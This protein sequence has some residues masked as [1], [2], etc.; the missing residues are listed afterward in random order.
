MSS[1]DQRVV[2][3]RFNNQQF[4][5]G[6]SQSTQSLEKLKKGLDLEGSAKSLTNL[7]NAG[8]NFSLANISSGI[9]TLVS[10]FSS[11]GI[12]GMTVLQNIT[13]QALYAGQNLAAALTTTPIFD[14]FSEYEIKMNSIQTLLT[15]TADKGSTLA[16]V[17]KILAE[18]NDYADQ[19]IYNKCKRY[20]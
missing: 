19:T 14:G 20:G 18:L 1:V 12:V 15:N 7:N 9:D 13:N 4:E 2:D 10:K 8:K 3:M 16:D 5:R 11:L 6:V 17:N